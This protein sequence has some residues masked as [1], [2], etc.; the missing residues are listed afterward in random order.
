MLLTLPGG[1]RASAATEKAV[2]RDRGARLRRTATR[3]V[4]LSLCL[5]LSPL[6][7]T[8]EPESLDLILDYLPGGV[9]A[10][11]LADLAGM[12]RLAYGAL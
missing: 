3:L 1:L 10:L 5:C 9:H 4:S 8:A 7:R 6:G 11:P 12:L 2:A